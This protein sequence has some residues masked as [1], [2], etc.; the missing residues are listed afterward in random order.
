MENSN[1]IEEILTFYDHNV[2]KCYAERVLQ[3]GREKAKHF[4][5]LFQDKKRLTLSVSEE[6]AA[7]Y[8]YETDNDFKH[9]FT[10]TIGF[11][12]NSDTNGA[13]KQQ[14]FKLA[15]FR[16]RITF[17]NNTYKFTKF[18][19][20][21]LNLEKAID[22]PQFYD[23]L[24]TAQCILSIE[25][26][27][28][29][30]ASENASF[31]SCFSIDSCHHTGCTAYL[32]DKITM[33]AYTTMNNRKIGRQWIYFD[34]FYVIFGRIYGAISQPVQDK[35]RA[36]LEERY[37]AHL[38]IPNDWILK[39]ELSLPSDCVDNCGHGK[40]DHDEYAVYFDLQT[41]AVI[42]AKNQTTHFDAIS[43]CFED[44][45]NADGDD[46][47]S[48]QLAENHCACCGDSMDGEGNSTEDGQVCHYCYERY[49]SY[50]N[51]CECHYHNETVTMYYIEDLQEYVCKNCYESGDYGYCPKMN[52]YYSRDEMTELIVNK[53]KNIEVSR[54]WAEDNAYYCQHCD[55]YFEECESG[56]E[57]VCL[58]CLEEYYQKAEDGS[59]YPKQAEAA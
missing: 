35:I 11:V 42:R 57:H 55:T 53:E 56:M 4:A 6:E 16:N 49:Y 19:N 54:D 22:F 25:P 12:K 17:Q 52:A 41:N 23:K 45:I 44:G 34:N 39:R 32:R 15:I 31:S 51:D 29:L 3:F 7:S 43:L 28:F 2:S 24:K 5:W 58:K 14:N 33:I 10:K 36:L 18:C 26:M 30:S 38:Q 48:G 50:C 40:N 8:F 27:D 47:Q 21:F 20:R 13:E 59:Y 37:A 46:T 1:Q 9:L